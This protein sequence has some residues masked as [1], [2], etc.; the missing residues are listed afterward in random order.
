ME[1]CTHPEVS[2][3]CPLPPPSHPFTAEE[4][5]SG[6]I[7]GQRFTWKSGTDYVEIEVKEWR[8]A[9]LGL[10]AVAERMET[11][12][13][14]R[15]TI[16]RGNYF[17]LVNNL[18]T[19]FILQILVCCFHCDLQLGPCRPTLYFVSYKVTCKAYLPYILE[20]KPTLI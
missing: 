11:S 7:S 2:A 12:D 17:I 4:W 10:M 1:L 20:H 14:K 8:R 16:K 15:F 18:R 5:Q 13:R 9:G 19:G 3:H 6:S